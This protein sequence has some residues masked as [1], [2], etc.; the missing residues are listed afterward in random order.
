[1]SSPTNNHHAP[2]TMAEYAKMATTKVSDPLVPHPN[3]ITTDSERNLCPVNQ[4]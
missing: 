2:Y 3:G 4:L 1:M